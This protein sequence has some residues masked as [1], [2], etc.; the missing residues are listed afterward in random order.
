MQRINFS[1]V[2]NTG[3]FYLSM[4]AGMSF[5]MYLYKKEKFQEIVPTGI[6][7]YAKYSYGFIIFLD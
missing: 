3:E 7:L 4:Y 1:I 6:E 2:Y 5:Y